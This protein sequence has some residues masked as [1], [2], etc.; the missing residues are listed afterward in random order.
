[1]VDMMHSSNERFLTKRCHFDTRTSLIQALAGLNA[2]HHATG[3]LPTSLDE[4]VPT[5]LPSVPED[6]FDGN[7][8][9]YSAESKTVYSVGDDFTDD[10]PPAEASQT[11]SEA[12]AIRL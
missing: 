11:S 10:G 2:Y 12:P 5:Y 8:L 4:L 1:M 9:R 6:R 7:P 3:R